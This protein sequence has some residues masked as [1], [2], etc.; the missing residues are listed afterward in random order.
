MRWS[1]PFT[2]I[3]DVTF[4]FLG[5]TRTSCSLSSSR[6]ASMMSDFLAV[7][8]AIYPSPL[9]LRAAKKLATLISSD[10]ENDSL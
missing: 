5:S 9:P 1:R 6:K 3:T 10:Q 7:P 4:T 8:T 2:S